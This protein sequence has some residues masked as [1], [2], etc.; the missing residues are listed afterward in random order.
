M[1]VGS[2]PITQT[3][4]KTPIKDKDKKRPNE[5]PSYVARKVNQGLRI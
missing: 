5:S 4:A 1:Q 2:N 3:R